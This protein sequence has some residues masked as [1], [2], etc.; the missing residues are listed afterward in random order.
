VHVFV[1]NFLRSPYNFS[2]QFHIPQAAIAF[3]QN[4][5]ISPLAGPAIYMIPLTTFLVFLISWGIIA[6]LQ[7]IPY[8]RSLVA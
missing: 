4:I 2:A 5:K 8:V 3:L 1:L 6:V 7:R